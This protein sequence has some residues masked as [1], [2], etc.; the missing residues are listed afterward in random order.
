M[1]PREARLESLVRRLLRDR[2]TNGKRDFKEQLALYAFLVSVC[3]LLL[4]GI[5]SFI[6]FNSM[7]VSRRALVESNRAFVVPDGMRLTGS[8]ELR[9]DLPFQLYYVNSGKTLANAELEVETIIA[10]DP[11]PAFNG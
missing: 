3:A 11:A 2:E 5:G 10:S 8:P 7:E 6:A 1:T 4:N 9:K